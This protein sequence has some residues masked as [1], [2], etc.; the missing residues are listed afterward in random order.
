MIHCRSCG[1]QTKPFM[2]LG[3]QPL[4]N[5]LVN[6]DDY[7]SPEKWYELSPAICSNC[8]LFQ[9]VEQPDSETMFTEQYPF[10]TSS[11]RNMSAHF[12]DFGSLLIAER[13]NIKTKGFVVEIGSNDGTF[14]KPFADAGITHL[15]VEPS[16]NVGA[17]AR[18]RGINTKV[19]FFGY[20]TASE[21][22]AKYGSANLIIAANV[23]GHIA[24]I[25]DLGRGVA[26]LLAEDGHFVFE[27]VYLGDVIKNTAFDQ[28]YDEHVFTFSATSVRNA[29]AKHKLELID[30]EHQVVHGGSMRFFLA[31]RGKYPVR[32]SV[33]QLLKNEHRDGLN[34]EETY[35]KFRCRTETIRK[36]LIAQIT[37]LNSN[38]QFVVGYGA[39][40]KSSTVLNYCDLGS[41][42]IAWIQDSTR[43]KQG[44]LTPGTHIPIVSPKVFQESSP[45]FAVL[46]AW[47]HQIEI[48]KK[49]QKWRANGGKWI[50]YIPRVAIQ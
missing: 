50:T 11:S 48:E 31:H 7:S 5:A 35:E 19:A 14:L 37:T 46:F 40:A 16:S 28:L 8:Y 20:E 15:G 34:S 36:N 2:S 4:A 27:A 41:N 18:E 25:N 45:D 26:N 33:A 22:H 42:H 17:I 47:N 44:K 21:I 10:F 13:P 24:D 12:E 38:G 49:E 32:P 39:T 30:I 3:S 29:F 23:I 43:E 1:T 9:L 6:P